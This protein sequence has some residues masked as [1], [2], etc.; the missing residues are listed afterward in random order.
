MISNTGGSEGRASLRRV[1]FTPCIGPGAR[2]LAS[3]IDVVAAYCRSCRG[4]SARGIRS[5]SGTAATWPPCVG[6]QAESGDKSN[7]L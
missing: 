6:L 3:L 7:D 1:G 5:A 4:H 2:R